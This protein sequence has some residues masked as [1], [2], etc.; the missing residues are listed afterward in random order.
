MHD[1]IRHQ[2]VIGSEVSS[3]VVLGRLRDVATSGR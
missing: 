3:I 2:P 1:L